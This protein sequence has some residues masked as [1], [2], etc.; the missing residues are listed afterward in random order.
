MG[1]KLSGTYQILAYADDMSL[2][3]NNRDSTKKSTEI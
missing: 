3:R 1:L 2:L